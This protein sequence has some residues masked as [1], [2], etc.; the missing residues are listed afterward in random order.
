MATVTVSFDGTRVND[1]E[2]LGTL[3]QDLGGGAAVLEG[4][5]VYQGSN[6]V[7][8]K[9]KTT[10]LG[11]KYYNSGTSHDYS[12][13][14]KIAILK[15]LVTTPGILSSTPSTSMIAEI[16]SGDRSAYYR[17]YIAT[18]TTY[19]KAGGWLIIPIDPSI[20]GYRDAT[21]NTP[22]LS[23][24][25][26]YAHA[27]TM[28]STSKAEN[29][30]MDAIDFVDSGKG[31]TLVGGDGASTDGVFQDFVDFDEG[32]QNNSY[33]LWTTK[34]GIFY[35]IGVATIGT[36]TATVFT[37]SNKVVVFPDGRFDAGGC[38]IKFDLQ[39]ATTAITIDNCLFNSQGDTATTD[40]RPDYTVTGTS[41]TLTATGCTFNVY[42][43]ATFT[44]A[45][46]FTNC[47]FLNG[48]VIDAG[49]GATLTG[50]SIT[51]STVAADT[52]ALKWN[53]NL[54][55]NGELDN[56][57]ISK[58][59]NAHHAIEFGTTSPL[60]MTL[61]GIDF[62]G[63]NA[64][65]GQN[66][67][68]FHVLRTSGTVTINIIGGSGNVSYKTAGATVVIVQ[69]PVALTLTVLDITTGLPI[70]G[71]RAYV[72]ADSVGPL[73]YQDSVTITRSGSIASVVHT[74]HGLSNGDKVLI[75]GA[76]QKEYNGV[77]TI[78]NVTVNG[79]DYTVSGAPATPAT[80]TIT[81]TAVIIDGTTN[82]SG[83]ISDTRTY[84]S[85]QDFTGRVRKSTAPSPFYKTQPITGTI[86]K[87]TGLS[88]TVSL[89]RDE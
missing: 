6:S 30:A 13:T 39:N 31:L 37:D 27:A 34:E 63:F 15:M 38:G 69:N 21:V 4:D 66:D 3:W 82:A 11:V 35:T 59:T 23:A 70:N 24:I 81:S 22:T 7:S 79:Y 47:S 42:R 85:D 86:D 64:S 51:N 16:G 77:H 83:I 89:V 50:T 29:V 17:Y 14:A 25:D 8:E 56:M 10:E 1:A 84:S 5:F 49:S 68:T 76:D 18:N 87:D 40:T 71:A 60:T 2:A 58:G 75:K 54:D 55:P 19:P 20:P 61:T 12:T 48:G 9:V 41:G 53:V 52:S 32:T 57:S 67:S 44:S 46:T 36:A 62:S 88:I 45:C 26:Y 28:S 33:G 65:N 72:I 78:S 80:G 43:N 73:P 74:A